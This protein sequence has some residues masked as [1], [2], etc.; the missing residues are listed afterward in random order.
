[1]V[2][3]PGWLEPGSVLRQELIA[4]VR[5]QISLDPLNALDLERAVHTLRTSPWVKDV[6]RIERVAIDQVRVHADYRVPTALLRTR[7]G[8]YLVDAEGVRLLE[9]PYAQRPQTLM[10]VIAGVAQPQP[11]VGQVWPGEDVQAALNL[12]HLLQTRPYYDQVDAIDVSQRARMGRIRMTIVATNGGEILW[13]FPPGTESVT[14]RDDAFKLANID[15]H[16]RK[17]S[18]IAMPRQV[19]EVYNDVVLVR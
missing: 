1:L 9:M 4:L 8:Y 14:E 16:Y 18:V 2:N 5:D 19:V 3:A 10:P 17:F 7:Q 11:P 13:G 6:H 15:E 12:I